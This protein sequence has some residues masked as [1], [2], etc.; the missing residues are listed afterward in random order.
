MPD[1]RLSAYR[2]SQSL[3]AR[4]EDCAILFDE[5]EDIFPDHGDLLLGNK[6]LRTG[7]KAWINKLLEQNEVPAF[8]VSNSVSQI[9][10]AFLRRFDY[11]LELGL[12]PR[13]VRKGVLEKHLTDLPVREACIERMAGNAYLTP[14]TIERAAKIVAHLQ[15]AEPP[16]VEGALE[17]V[18]G[19]TLEVMGL[20]RQT[21]DYPPSV[22]DYSLRFL[23]PDVDLEQLAQ[24]LR[25]NPTARLCLY[26]PPGTGKTGFGHYLANELDK[27]LLKMHASTLLNKYVGGTEKNLLR[28]F[29]MAKYEDAVLLL[30]E[31]DSFLQDRT[32]AT[33]RWEV[34]LVNELLVQME[35]FDGVFI[36][37]TN[38]M[39]S[40]DPACLRRF[41][42]KIRFDYLDPDGAWEI[43]RQVLKD[44][45]HRIGKPATWR[46]RLQAL[47]NLTPGDF[48]N[49]VRQYRLSKE[50]MD[51]NR[52]FAALEKECLAK[53]GVSRRAIGFLAKH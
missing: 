29:R 36:A 42:F 6:T 40:L 4:R 31:A 37:S 32:G 49:A 41:D 21:N 46:R 7:K 45:G 30:D 33:H 1:D 47:T 51:A 22:T 8:W 35:S 50:P 44:H 23:N 39:D 3:L 19:N 13:S 15:H 2:I 24:G 34:S 20:P 17:R 38:L 16:Q 43:F 14:A 25:R 11:V 27:P 12:P 28:M 5:I 53:P 18:I 48:A 52:L 9:D 10:R 26:G